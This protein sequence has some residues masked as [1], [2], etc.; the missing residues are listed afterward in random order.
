MTK[1]AVVCSQ[2]IGDLLIMHI[3]SHNLVQAGFEL[4]TF[5][6]HDF[7]TWVAGYK[8]AKQPLFLSDFD[9]II[10]QYDNS[11]KVKRI[12]NTKTKI[13]G[14]YGN[15]QLSKHGPL[16]ESDYVCNPLLSMVDNITLAMQKWFGLSSKENGLTPPPSLI[17]KKY[18]KRVAIHT[19]SRDP[20]RNWPIERFN[21][22][23]TYLKQKGYDPV[24]LEQFQTLEDL[25]SFI[26]ESGSF[27]GND[28]GPG[29]LASCLQIPSIIIGTSYNHLL[30]WRPGWLPPRVVTPPR[31]TSTF[32]WTRKRWKSFI[33]TRVIK[34]IINNT[35]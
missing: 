2:G 18:P 23:A 14:F 33:P 20:H 7:G 28:S 25:A 21:K 31:W 3:A 35:N 17:H 26:Y 9:A 32:K 4:V 29:H 5:S 15:H 11:D 13:Y 34:M 24:F 19:G 16:S 27:I 10:L 22:I 6:E 8:F 12:K 30:L 1:I